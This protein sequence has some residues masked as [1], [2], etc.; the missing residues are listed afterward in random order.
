MGLL[1]AERPED[2]LLGEEGA[3]GARRA[4]LGGGPAGRDHQLPLRDP[5]VGRVDRGGGPVGGLAGVVFAPVAGELF[6]AQRGAGA[7]LNGEPLRIGED[8]ELAGALVATGFGYE[9]D[10]RREQASDHR[11]ILPRVRDLRRAG[12]ASLDLA[13][14]A[15]GRLDGYWERG[16]NA[17]DWAAGR[18]LV[19]EAGGALADLGGEPP[20]L[21][22]AIPSLLLLRSWSHLVDV[23][24]GAAEASSTQPRAT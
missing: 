19:T 9:A 14:L 13:W 15:A 7:D 3:S 23:V 10:R 20:G 16:L 4:P 5:A 21:A 22:A 6:R 18:L 8:K 24:T 1:R 17:W 11:D 12:A 2:G